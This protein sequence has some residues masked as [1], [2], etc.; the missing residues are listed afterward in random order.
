MS[1]LKVV[2]DRGE[3][4]APHMFVRLHT[5]LATI[6]TPAQTPGVK[7]RATC[8]EAGSPFLQFQFC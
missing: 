2:G 7:F 6:L 1:V 5:A 3:R 8:V 4:P